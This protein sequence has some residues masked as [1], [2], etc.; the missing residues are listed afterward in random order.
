MKR[1]DFFVMHTS[2]PESQADKW[3]AFQRVSIEVS[4]LCNKILFKNA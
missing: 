3:K 1:N 4:I 2:T